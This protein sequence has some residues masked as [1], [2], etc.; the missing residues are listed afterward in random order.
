MTM[1]KSG[2]K[3]TEFS[4]FM[5]DFELLLAKAKNTQQKN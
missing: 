1:D 4:N 3:A 5:R 2:S